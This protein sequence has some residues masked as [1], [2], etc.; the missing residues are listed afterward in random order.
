[1]MRRDPLL[2]LGCIGLGCAAFVACGLLLIL[3]LLIG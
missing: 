3:Y 1:M 2:M